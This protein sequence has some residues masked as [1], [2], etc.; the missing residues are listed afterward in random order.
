MAN[1]LIPERL[2]LIREKL[3]ITKT[4]ASRKLNL[5]KIGYCRYEYGER[6]PSL[7]TV[8]IIAQRFNTSVDYLVGLTEDASPN[9]I[10]IDKKENPELFKLVELCRHDDVKQLKRL[11]LYYNKFK[12]GL[13]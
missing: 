4:E 3:G 1:Q 10:I 8:E 13:N 2:R 5:S 6:I 12:N 7:Q 11:L 9:Q